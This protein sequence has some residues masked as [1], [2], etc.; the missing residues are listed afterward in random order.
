[1]LSLDLGAMSLGPMLGVKL[2]KK[3][4]KNIFFSGN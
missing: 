3:K 4:E 1:M 2:L